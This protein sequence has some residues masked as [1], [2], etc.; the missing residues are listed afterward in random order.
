ML[1]IGMDAKETPPNRSIREINMIE[2]HGF[3]ARPRIV[4]EWVSL[5]SGPQMTT[6]S[7]VHDVVAHLCGV[8]LWGRKARSLKTEREDQNL[9][10]LKSLLHPSGVATAFP[11]A[12]A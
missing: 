10:I 8:Q 2:R 6:E 11:R 1:H 12:V 3:G 7:A 4:F 9:L 5:A